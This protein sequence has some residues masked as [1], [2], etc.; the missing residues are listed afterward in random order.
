MYAERLYIGRGIYLPTYFILSL[1][2]RMVVQKGLMIILHC[3]F[4]A[5]LSRDKD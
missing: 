2:D 1:F 5:D 4:V 3:Y